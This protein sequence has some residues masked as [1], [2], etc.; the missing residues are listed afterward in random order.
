MANIGEGTKITVKF[1][2]PGLYPGTTPEEIWIV[3]A[4]AMR[5]MTADEL[6]G[7][8]RQTLLQAGG[9][10]YPPPYALTKQEHEVSW[11]A[12]SEMVSWIV[13]LAKDATTV[14][15]FGTL[16]KKIVDAGKSEGITYPARDSQG[17]EHQA[18]WQA[19][20]T[21]DLRCEPDD[22]E[23]YSSERTQEAW[24]VEVANEDT[25]F[26]VKMPH[27]LPMAT[28]IGHRPR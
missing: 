23:L 6:E 24:L 20:S 8:I 5:G 7:A 11:G 25:I 2:K 21:F 22:L 15:A 1:V 13:E 12:S 28:E 10:E 19:V 27:D 3:D 16:I 4:F 26:R 18:R 17:A 14:A 9:G